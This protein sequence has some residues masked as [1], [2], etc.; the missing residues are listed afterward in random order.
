HRPLFWRI[1]M[2]QRSFSIGFEICN[3]LCPTWPSPHGYVVE[4][5]T[6]RLETLPV[7]FGCQI[8]YILE[9]NEFPNTK[10]EVLP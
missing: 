2:T 8:M 1:S 7:L 6:G 10:N 4:V 9:L 3:A 5:D